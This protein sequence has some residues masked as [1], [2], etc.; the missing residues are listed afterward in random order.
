MAQGS[1]GGW[2]TCCDG[3]DSARLVDDLHDAPIFDPRGFGDCLLEQR[4]GC[5]T[6]VLPPERAIA[7]IPWLGNKRAEA[8][9][10]LA[11]GRQLDTDLDGRDGHYWHMLLWDPLRHQLIGGQ[12]LKFV[13]HNTLEAESITGDQSYLEH[14]YPG[15]YASLVRDGVSFAEVGRTFVM[16]GYQGKHWLGE[17]I[18]GFVHLPE[19]RRIHLAFGMVSFD[20]REIKSEVVAAFI[21]CLD[22]SLFRGDLRLPAPRYAYPIDLVTQLPFDW[23]GL[24]LSA[25]E[26]MLRLLDDRFLLP[27]VLRPYRVLCSVEY[28]GLSV[29]KS[30]NQR[31][32]LLFS[33]RSELITRQQR[34]RLP[35]YPVGCGLWAVSCEL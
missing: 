22:G 24:E 3:P 13:H 34:R 32:Q 35:P 5:W 23:D 19:Q 17:L 8:F 12:R 6:F 1:R 10:R 20:Q 4:H 9:S 16:P 29:A 33:G 18:R 11:P 31:L 26:V 30:Y 25:L 7:I 2:L 27:P 28:E 14:S 15:I 21:R